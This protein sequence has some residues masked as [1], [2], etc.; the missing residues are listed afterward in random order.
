MALVAILGFAVTL[1]LLIKHNGSAIVLIDKSL[2]LITVTV[3]PALP[4][5][6][7]AGVAFA[8]QRLKR[9]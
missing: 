6:M 4:A 7:S 3:P 2:D 5:T 9:K 8:V 1:P